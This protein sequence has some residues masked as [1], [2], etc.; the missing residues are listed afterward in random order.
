[1]N[2]HLRPS[3][4]ISPNGLGYLWLALGIILSLFAANGRWDLGPAAWLGPLFFLRFTR[5]RGPLIGFAGVWLASVGTMLFFL[6]ESELLNPLWI[7]V[8]LIFSTVLAL[9][10]LLD[11]LLAPRLCLVSVVLATLVF[12]LSRA[13]CEYLISFTPY[14]SLLSLAY[15]QYGNLPL[16]QLLFVTGIYG[17]S[18]LMAWFA[19]VGN[20]IWEQHFA[21]PRIRTVTLLYSGLLALV[22]LGGN[23]RLTFF[24]PSAPT[25]RVAGISAASSTYDQT[26]GPRQMVQMVRTNPSHLRALLAA[27]DN[28][29]LD[30]SRTEARAGAKIVIWPE[31]GAVAL[32]S[33]ET[34]LITQAATLAQQ[35]HIYLEMGLGVFQPPATF[36]DQAILI[37]PE[38]RVVW[39]YNK[40]HPVPGLDPF[41]P[42]DTSAPVVETP[43]GRLST[44]ICFDADFPALMRDAGSKR[45]DIMLVPSNDWQASDPWHTHDATFRAIENGY[46]LVLQASKGLA[47]TVDSQGRVLAATDYFTTDQQ[48]MIAFVPIQGVWT[49]YSVVGDLFAWLCIAGMFVLAGFV[50]FLSFR[51]RLPA[52]APASESSSMNTEDGDKVGAKMM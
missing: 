26:P 19:S 42:G 2:T 31:V 6:Y 14:G 27:L 36:H 33:D 5:T 43:Y 12:P 24:A 49:I 22:L 47:M 15:T 23:L 30:R 25:I 3:K 40:A 39:T 13:A 9:P 8:F 17:V 21:W 18:F 16:L 50:A 38:G 51:K 46:S 52:H 10:Y 1:M 41:A 35:E 4:G 20:G 32:A 29:L 28:E 45:V 44:V 11:R 34:H 48:T 7:V 37:D